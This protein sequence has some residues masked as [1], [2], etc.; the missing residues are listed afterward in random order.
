MFIHY[1]PSL[2]KNNLK[3]MSFEDVEKREP[4]CTVGGNINP[5]ATVENRWNFSP[6]LII[7]L[8]Y[9]PAILHLGMCLKNSKTLTWKDTSTSMFQFSRS[10]V[11]DFA[12]PWTAARQASLSITNSRSPP[13]PVSIESVMPSNHLIHSLGWTDVCWQSNVSAFEYAV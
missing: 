1:L 9:D 13:K 5:W 10:V 3:E 11:S 12:T 7:E 4:L 6:K 8:P 2:R